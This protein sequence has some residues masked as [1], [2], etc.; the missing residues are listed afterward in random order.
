MLAAKIIMDHTA[1]DTGICGDTS[2]LGAGLGG[3]LDGLGAGPFIKG[4]NKTGNRGQT[5]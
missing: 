3:D 5:I 1:L 2:S 4:E